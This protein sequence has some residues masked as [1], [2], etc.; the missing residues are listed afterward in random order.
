[1]KISPSTVISTIKKASN[2]WNGNFMKLNQTQ[3]AVTISA[4]AARKAIIICWQQKFSLFL[5]SS[6]FLI[7][8]LLSFSVLLHQFPGLLRYSRVSFVIPVSP[9]SVS[10]SPSSFPPFFLSSFS[11]LFI[12]VIPASPS[13]FPRRR[14]SS[15]VHKSI[16]HFPINEPT[17]AWY[18][19]DQLQS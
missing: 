8:V 17:L 10:A 7:L 1:M 11:H 4:I 19:K 5:S 12:F 13:S 9:S 3:R 2:L 14:E 15:T 16:L 6:L 18:A